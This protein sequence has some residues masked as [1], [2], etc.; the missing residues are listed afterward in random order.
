[1]RISGGSL[2][3]R[4]VDVPPGIIRPSM[5]RMRESVFAVLGDLSNHSFLDLFSGSG[6]IAL[7]AASRGAALVEA[8]ES[9]VQKRKVL[10][11][12]V[13]MS[14]I[15]IHC[16]FIAV[17]LYIKRAKK[18][19]DCIFCDPPFS[20]RFKKD[21]IL[22]I[23]SSPLMTAGSQ[24]LIHKPKSEDL[25]LNP[26]PAVEEAPLVLSESRYYGNSE[27]LFFKNITRKEIIT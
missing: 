5:D 4:K 2:R 26:A 9:D 11:K 3:G 24:L 27:V 14:S 19:F 8:V 18:P 16:H 23:L 13:S 10:L 1:M 22:S 20:Y 17:E 7:E 6:S 12:N 15:R 21:L 25:D